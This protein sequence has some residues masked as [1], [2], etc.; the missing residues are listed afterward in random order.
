MTAT[1]EKT[2]RDIAIENPSTIRVFETLG[3]DY[4]CGGRRSLADACAAANV[5]VARTLELLEDAQS[6]RDDSDPWNEVPLHALTAHIVTKHHDFV[7]RE[8]E[9]IQGLLTKVIARHGGAN[10]QV[11]QIED[12]FVAMTQELRTHMLQEERKLFPCI[13]QMEAAGLNVTSGPIADRIAAMTA[14]HDS[15]GALMARIRE[16]AAAF[17]APADACPTFRALYHSLAGFE[18]D[19]HRHV[20]LENNILFPRAVRIEA[21]H[22][23]ARQLCHAVSA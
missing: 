6:P 20:H 3:I 12:L 10:P 18:S 16:H 7:R 1:T 15:A 9:R 11:R 5:S 14:D 2:V 23:S 22:E 13:E 4:C 8:T 21:A 19:L 17:V